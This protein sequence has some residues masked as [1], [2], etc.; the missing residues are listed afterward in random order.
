[1]KTGEDVERSSLEIDFWSNLFQERATSVSFDEHLS[2]LLLTKD[3]PKVG[4]MASSEPETIGAPDR[5]SLDALVREIEYFRTG[6]QR[7]QN[8]LLELLYY[9]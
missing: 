2:T 3:P 7:T 1:M 5:F 4:M 8:R 9:I 6:E